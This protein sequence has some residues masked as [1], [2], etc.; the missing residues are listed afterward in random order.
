MGRALALPLLI[1]SLADLGAAQNHPAPLHIPEG[2]TLFAYWNHGDP[3]LFHR[4]CLDNWQRYNPTWTVLL[5][6]QE[7]AVRAVGRHMLPVTFYDMSPQLQSDSVRLAAL[8]VYGGAWLDITSF[9]VR[10]NALD[11]MYAEMTQRGAQLRGYSWLTDHIFESWFIMALPNSVLMAQW[12]DIFN[13]YWE[14]RTESHEIEEHNLFWGTN[15]VDKNAILNTWDGMLDYL[16]IHA[17]FLRTVALNEWGGYEGGDNHWTR[18]VML[19]PGSQGGYYVEMGLC[20]SDE[21]CLRDQIYNDRLDATEVA[22][23][24]PL[25]KFNSGSVMALGIDNDDRMWD[26]FES[27]TNSILKQVLTIPA[28]PRP[29]T[30]PLPPPPQSPPPPP[31]IPPPPPSPRL[32]SAQSPPSPRSPPHLRSS[33]APGSSPPVPSS[34]CACPSSGAQAASPALIEC[35]QVLQAFRQQAPPVANASLDGSRGEWLDDG[36][37]RSALAASLAF[38]VILWLAL[39]GLV[40]YMRCTRRAE[41]RRARMRVAEHKVDAALEMAGVNG[42][43]YGHERR[44]RALSANGRK[45][46]GR[47]RAGTAEELAGVVPEYGYETRTIDMDL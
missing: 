44:P 13:A 1:V 37:T 42:G 21:G 22:T 11:Q 3:P 39:L 14:S 31:S 24:T 18:D 17:C 7:T 12:H 6:S 33:P 28:Q 41:D 19:E 16:S 10:Q 2:R 34:S 30:P 23:H 4:R 36:G 20:D 47:E 38:N 27:E 35:R 8:R 15:P 26:V 45:K 40:C 32:P 9:F 46:K 43:D 29:P 5:L 25:I